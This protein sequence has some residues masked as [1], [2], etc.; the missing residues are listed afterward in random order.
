MRQRDR[1][2]HG[3]AKPESEPALRV[4]RGGARVTTAAPHASCA[5]RAGQPGTDGATYPIFPWRMHTHVFGPIFRFVFF[6]QNCI[7]LLII[8]LSQSSQTGKTETQDTRGFPHTWNIKLKATERQKPTDTANKAGG[9]GGPKGQRLSEGVGG[10]VE[11]TGTQVRGDGRRAGR[12]VSTQHAPRPRPCGPHKV[13]PGHLTIT[14]G[15]PGPGC[16]V[17]L[18]QRHRWPE[19]HLY[20]IST[21]TALKARARKRGSD[22]RGRRTP[23]L[24]TPNVGEKVHV[25]RSEMPSTEGFLFLLLRP[26]RN[27]LGRQRKDQAFAHVWKTP[28]D[29]AGTWVSS[30]QRGRTLGPKLCAETLRLAQTSTQC[31]LWGTAHVKEP[32]L[33]PSCSRT[34][35]HAPT[36]G[37]GWR[38]GRCL[39]L[40]LPPTSHPRSQTQ[41]WLGP[42]REFSHTLRPG[43]GPGDE[44][45]TG[46]APPR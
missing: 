18:A 2:V 41:P 46:P 40:L 23:P 14:N 11:G 30:V 24:F 17:A 28:E 4:P 31:P 42:P 43:P 27:V 45:G 15:C 3:P 13:T 33:W 5:A 6:I 36:R 9:G 34:D 10:G 8:T 21:D 25:S 37:A 32:A 16:G 7:C 26:L 1:G 35:G 29:A 22:A 20:V 19:L 44:D 12:V 39:L 38:V